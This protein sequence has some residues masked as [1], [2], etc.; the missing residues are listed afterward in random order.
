MDSFFLFF[1]KQ[2]DL[3]QA[4]ARSYVGRDKQLKLTPRQLILRQ[5][6]RRRREMLKQDTLKIGIYR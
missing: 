2:L 5:L 4:Y 3:R 1:I 6:V